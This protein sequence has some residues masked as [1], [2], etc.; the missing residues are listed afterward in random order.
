M[1][2]A[3][4][5]SQPRI[6]PAVPANTWELQDRGSS[7]ASLISTERLDLVPNFY[8]YSVKACLLPIRR[9]QH[10]LVTLY[11]HHIHPMFPV[12]DEY[13]MTELHQTY[14]GQEEL[15]DPSDFTVYHAIMVAGFAVRKPNLSDL[16]ARLIKS[17]CSISARRKF[18]R[19]HT[20][21][22]LKVKKHKLSN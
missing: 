13:R 1:T 9:V 22:S 20:D 14:R 8:T 3:L 19:P 10:A 17:N 18:L 16:V 5:S 7:D 15:M 11:F 6:A 12:V 4:V 2:T 21:P